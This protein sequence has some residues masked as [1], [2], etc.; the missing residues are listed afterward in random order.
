MRDP[1]NEVV[2][3]K[4]TVRFSLVLTS[5]I[6]LAALFCNRKSR[7]MFALDVILQTAPP[8]RNKGSMVQL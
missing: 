5:R 4:L 8:Y 6:V 3:N 2:L 7:L 1:G